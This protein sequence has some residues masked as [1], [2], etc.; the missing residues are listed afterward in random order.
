M[1]EI[2]DIDAHSLQSDGPNVYE[3]LETG[4]LVGDE[5]ISS[6]R[7]ANS[8]GKIYDSFKDDGQISPGDLKVVL[9]MFFSEDKKMSGDSRVQNIYKEIVNGRLSE[10]TAKI[11]E[12][13]GVDS[14]KIATMP[15]EIIERP[16]R[17]DIFLGKLDLDQITNSPFYA[18]DSYVEGQEPYRVGTAVVEGYPYKKY[19]LNEKIDQG[20]IIL[21][22]IVIGDL[23]SFER[24]QARG[25]IMPL[26][27][28]GDVDMGSLSWPPI[29]GTDKLRDKLRLRKK[30]EELVMPQVIG[31]SLYLNRVT[32]ARGVIM[33][34]QVGG[35]IILSRLESAEG[36]VLPKI[37]LGEVRLRGLKE[38]EKEEI[39]KSRPDLKI[40]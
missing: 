28:T 5:V 32:S 37:V 26:E 39:R 14:K 16:D 9:A 3:Q 25:L 34:E 36:L 10:A 4:D 24:V 12:I 1:S 40:V 7:E 6:R 18:S 30:Q 29:G 20:D 38:E 27:V 15:K 2:K 21:P 33:P 17:Q 22:K 8:V 23:I 31:G 11:A 13:F 19:F 35:D